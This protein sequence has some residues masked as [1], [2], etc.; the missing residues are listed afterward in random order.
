MN[1]LANIIT[2]IRIFGVGV[3]FWMTPYTNNIIQMLVILLYVVICLTD[4]LDGWVAR[5]LKIVSDLGK[6]LDP[7]ADK[8]LVLLFLPLL[9]MQVITS[10]PV[11]IILARE[12][13]MMG[14]RIYSVQSGGTSIPSQFTGKLKTAIT[15]PVCGMLFARV[16]VEVLDVPQFLAPLQFLVTWV[17]ELPESYILLLVYSVVALTVWS[18]ID[19]FDH[20]IWQLYLN[21]FNNDEEKAL[22]SLRS[23]IPNLF[24]I[25]N[26]VFGFMG[27][28]NA[29]NQNFRFS[30]LF[31]I[32]S[33]V[34]DAIDGSLARKLNAETKIGEILDSL[35]DFVSFGIL[36]ATV[37][38]YYFFDKSILLASSL[39]ILHVSST[40][41]RLIRFSST[42]HQDFFE[43][44]PSPFAAAFI[45]FSMISTLFN[46]YYFFICIV[47]FSSILMI[48]T[49]PYPH[50]HLAKEKRFLKLVQFPAFIFTLLSIAMLI[51]GKEGVNFYVYDILVIIYFL[52]LLSPVV[53]WKDRIRN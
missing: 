41:F 45:M 53:Y 24:S 46:A 48:S 25:L 50:R 28:Y 20:F 49:L 30:A 27:I 36:P 3:I 35:A 43:G 10:F 18:F 23:I 2:I 37:I 12:F 8:I 13:A 5:R 11:F 40:L 42:G 32:L 19:Y 47:V 52:Y 38:F 26:L 44:I 16:P 21:R 33:V 6:I 29:I 15:F 17:Y 51:R 39:A 7:L 34:F 14:L 4:F 31:L 22:L 1:Q 9:E